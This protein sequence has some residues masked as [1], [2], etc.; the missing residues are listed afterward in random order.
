MGSSTTSKFWALKAPPNKNRISQP[1]L[2]N[3]EKHYEKKLA[4]DQKKREKTETS[5]T[6]L[7]SKISELSFAQGDLV[8]SVQ[9]VKSI[10]AELA[11]VNSEFKKLVEID[12]QEIKNLNTK[13]QRKNLL[14][15]KLPLLIKFFF[16]I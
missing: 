5:I 1:Q 4:E 15:L 2:E 6:D 14:N 12:T 16:V 9:M 10:E 3:M 7:K 11:A 13:V 8:V